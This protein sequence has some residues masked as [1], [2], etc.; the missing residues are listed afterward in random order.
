V[1]QTGE[2]QQRRQEIAEL[3][4][5]DS[6]YRD[7]VAKEN[8]REKHEK[9]WFWELLQNAKDSVEESQK[10]KVKLEI[11][12]DQI[13]FSHTGNPFE[14]DDILSLIIQGS[15][16]TGKEGKTGRFGTGFITT[17]LLS[18]EVYI[19]GKLINNQ[20]CFRFLLNRN[21]KDND[22]FY[23]LQQESNKCFDESIRDNSYLGDGEFQTKFTYILDER[24]KETAKTGLKCINE[25]IPIVLSF[26]EQIDTV[27][28]IE[29]ETTT[30]FFKSLIQ[31][32]ETGLI[33]EWQINTFVNKVCVTSIDTYLHKGEQFETCIIAQEKDGIETIF[34]LT[35]D[36]PRLFYTFPLIGTEEIGIP[37]IINSTNFDLRVERDGIYLKS[38]EDENNK[39]IIREALLNSLKSFAELFITKNL[40]GIFE[41][42]DFNCDNDNKFEWIDEEWFTLLK[43]D[44]L[45]LLAS[46]KII[47]YDDTGN[48][49]A[50]L[51]DLNV[52]FID[53]EENLKELWGL[54]SE[55]TDIKVPLAGELPN[56]IKIIK[57]VALV[58]NMEI[59]D[60]PFVFGIDKLINQFVEDKNS[61]VELE[62]VIKADVHDWLNRFYALIIK[63]RE[64]FPLD[65]NIALNQRGILIRAENINWDKCN[66]D[67]LILVSDLTG[68]NFADK[69]FSRKIDCKHNIHGVKDFNID[70]A[71]NELLLKLNNLTEKDINDHLSYQKCNARFLK[72]LISKNDKDTIKDLKI[73][74]GATENFFGRF[75]ESE[76]LRLTPKAYFRK[77]FPIY[78]NLIRDKDCLNDVYSEILTDED[79]KFL[80]ENGFVHLSPLVVKEDVNA[81]IKI[82]KDLNINE[83]DLN[84]LTDSDGQLRHEIK[85]NFSDFAYLTA[86]DGHI[87]DRNSTPKSSLE[88]LKFFLLEAVEKDILF[89]TDEQNIIIEDIENPIK[90]GQCLWIY[91][92]KRRNWINIKNE[93]EDSEKKLSS[94]TPSSKNLSELLKGDDTLIKTIRGEKQRL[95]LKKLGVSF[96]DLIRNTLL[97]D[98]ESESWDKVFTSMITSGI[99]PELALE[100]INDQNIIKEHEKNKKERELINRN[101]SIGKL[102]ED[103]FREYIEQMSKNGI[104]VSIKRE[105]FGSDYILTEESSD[106]VDDEKRPE[107]FFINDWL[108]ELK[109]TSGEFAAMTQ[110]QAKTAKEKK[111]RYALIV[112]PLDGT[113]PDIDYLRKNARVINDIGSKI[114][115][116]YNDFNEVEMRKNNLNNG[117]DGISVNIE[118][119]NIRFRVSSAVWNEKKQGIEEFIAENF[120]VKGIKPV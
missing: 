107:I 70:N 80:S 18:K 64:S 99:D 82:L 91:G 46:K 57:N 43:A 44:M 8:E 22:H 45:D 84:Q 32:H 28:I 10:I 116:L 2:I 100:I 81:T 112:V 89:N 61:L 98:K 111:E 97:S 48:N 49:R 50:C 47:Q 103:L 24:G 17:Y 20:G 5:A 19:T 42:F 85:I 104:S 14:L 56:W 113:E 34:S 62:K 115:V 94:E 26:N 66:D 33:S 23:T 7:I 79:Y 63:E 88:R 87:Y 114:D 37:V 75:H 65:K 71:K 59:Y 40:N 53:K 117:K 13:S 72:W 1:I 41:L 109:A 102:V 105:P 73:I 9:R 77:D 95:F 106:L 58:K 36:Y 29:K 16:K 52:P 90:L 30:T 51:C 76:H 108:V 25:L 4:H 74:L 21:A 68:L 93:A 15:S 12:D 83:N 27:T 54:L 55:T 96:S 69:L 118:D 86:S 6:V 119:H 120:R 39:K 35:N 3:R 101:Q 60:L 92:A 67:D 110:L 38:S 78:A 11:T 31:K